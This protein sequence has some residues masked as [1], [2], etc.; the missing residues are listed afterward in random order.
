MTAR[1][2]ISVLSVALAASATVA[3]AQPNPK[4]TA[5]KAKKGGT[6][7]PAKDA[8]AKDAGAK[9]DTGAK[10]AA[11]GATGTTTGAAAGS[12]AGASAGAQPSAGT[13]DGKPAGEGAPVQMTEDPPPRDINGTDENPDA[14]KAISDIDDRPAV[15]TAPVVVRTGYPIEEAL[16]PITLP[17]NMSE[18][19]ISPHTTVSPVTGAM[20]LRARYGITSKI[21]LGL[22]YVLAGLFDD[23]A[24][25]LS[26]TV[27]LHPGKA[28]GLDLTVMLQDWIGVQ[29]GVPVYIS[30]L[31]I[32]L[33]IGAPIKLQLTDQLAIGGLDDFLNIRLNKFAPSF[34]SE[35]QNATFA[36]DDIVNTIKSG[37]ELRVSLFGI[38]QYH[39]NLAII[40]RA[41][42]Q[43]EDFATGKTDGCDGECLTSFLHAGFKLSPRR[44]LDLGLQIGFDDLAHGGSF[45]PTGYLAFRI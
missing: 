8:G 32:S 33:A 37:G 28:L 30:P 1:R 13:P 17:Q 15:V 25:P 14:P 23:P 5:P 7:A 34:Y 16:R 27:G 29:V 38:Y 44:Y 43:M 20:A 11:A 2:L 45:A 41:G 24:T 26:D 21:Q 9:K 39:P 42:V 22:T 6:L 19:A 4:K 18:V 3:A 40:V 35:A 31:A 12:A 36:N 10:G